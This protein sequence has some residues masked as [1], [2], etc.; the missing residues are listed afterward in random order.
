VKIFYCLAAVLVLLSGCGLINAMAG[1]H[2]D[3]NGVVTTSP[4]APINTVWGLLEAFGPWGVGI[5]AAGRWGTVEYR[6]R[7]LIAAGKKD[8]NRDGVED[9]VTPS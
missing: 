2:T 8:A 1:V 9:P 6:H 4:N 7:Q 5:A 3:E